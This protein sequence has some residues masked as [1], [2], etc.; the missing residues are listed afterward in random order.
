M[1]LEEVEASRECDRVFII[2][3]WYVVVRVCLCVCVW[4]EWA[5]EGCGNVDSMK[6]LSMMKGQSHFGERLSAISSIYQQ[7]IQQPGP[8]LHCNPSTLL[9]REREGDRRQ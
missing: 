8:P 2:L 7:R 9:S 6:E 3:K 4:C 1:V 5:G